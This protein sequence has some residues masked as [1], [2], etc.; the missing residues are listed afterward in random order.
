LNSEDVSILIVDDESAIQV[1][2]AGFLGQRWRCTTASRADEAVQLLSTC[3]FDLIVTDINMPGRSGLDLCQDVRQNYPEVDVIVISALSD[4]EHAIQAMRCG[5]IDYLTKP[6]SLD[7]VTAS[8]EAA[9]AKQAANRQQRK[10]AESL[11]AKISQ[12]TDSLGTT[13]GHLDA[14]QNRLYSTCKA[15]I[16]GLARTLEARDLETRG[17]SDRVV[18]YS[19]RIGSAMNLEDHELTALE[20]GALL[21]DIGKIGVRDSV[22][23]KQGP[24]THEEWLVMKDHVSLGMKIISNIDFLAP[25]RFVIGQHHEKYDGSGYPSGLAGQAIHIAARV[26]AVADAYDAITSDRPYRSAMSHADACREIS[27]HSGTQFDPRVVEAFLRIPASDWPE[28]RRRIELQTDRE[29]GTIESDTHSVMVS[30]QFP[31]ELSGKVDVGC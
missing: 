15:A 2:L 7:Q 30:L 21:H 24:L 18:Q 8:V 19:L 6:F 22:L 9:L 12:D 25:A 10:Q 4:I 27:R 3:D 17:H 1:L 16:H 29:P 20:Q 14:V 5:A 26:F 11:E 13:N 23:L 28:I 31:I